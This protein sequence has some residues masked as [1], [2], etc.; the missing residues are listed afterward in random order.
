MAAKSLRGALGAM[1][2]YNMPASIIQNIPYGEQ[3]ILMET[4]IEEFEQKMAAEIESGEIIVEQITN[5]LH[6][7]MGTKLLF[8]TGEAKIK[9]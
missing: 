4:E 5:G 3:D 7:R 8:D 9:K 1:D 6:I 2:A